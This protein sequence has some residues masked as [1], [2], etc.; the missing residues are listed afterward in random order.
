MEII[1]T[2]CPVCEWALEFPREFANVTCGICGSAFQVREYK[3]NI[4]LAAI[5]EE[6]QDQAAFERASR[7][8]SIEARVTE[9][10]EDLA[11]VG[12]EIE[13]LRSNEQIAP[14]Q[15]GCAFF[16]MFGF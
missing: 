2:R 14:L 3:G 1:K 12:E 9:L 13:V 11:R 4:N 10:D 16:G 8:A 15:L 7:L 5:G 6:Q